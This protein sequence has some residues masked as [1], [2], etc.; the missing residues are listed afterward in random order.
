MPIE[1]PNEHM[2]DSIMKDNNDFVKNKN[3]KVN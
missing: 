2:I 3:I 1:N